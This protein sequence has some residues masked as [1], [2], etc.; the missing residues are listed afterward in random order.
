[1]RPP[2]PRAA[3]MT[4]NQPSRMHARRLGVLSESPIAAVSVRRNPRRGQ[5]ARDP[6]QFADE[7]VASCRTAAE[8]EGL[9]PERV[10]YCASLA[11]FRQFGA[12][13][14]TGVRL[15]EM[16]ALLGLYEPLAFSVLDAE[17]VSPAPRGSEEGL[18]AALGRLLDESL[19]PADSWPRV[20]LR[21]EED[22]AAGAAEVG[23]RVE[24]SRKAARCALPFALGVS[25]MIADRDLDFLVKA[26]DSGN[27]K[28]ARYALSYILRDDDDEDDE[29]EEEEAE[30][31]DAAA[32]A[33]AAGGASESGSESES[34]PR[35]LAAQVSAR[36]AHEAFRRMGE[37]T[38]LQHWARG[39][40]M[41]RETF[42]TN[43]ASGLPALPT[44]AS[45]LPS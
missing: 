11:L 19:P 13:V 5:L 7:L 43:V 30:A 44:Y 23:R 37:H 33:A 16:A 39:V 2:P 6:Q 31:D 42:I 14:G 45:A 8:A 22:E 32:A 36:V 9:E 4:T 29:D 17:G 21:G 18:A 34:A 40:A 28:T 12:E 38:W 41:D 27:I 35:P 26:V 10:L 25:H 1:M 24:V 15:G 3:M 20:Q